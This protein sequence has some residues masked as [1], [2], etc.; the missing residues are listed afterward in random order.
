MADIPKAKTMTFIPRTQLGGAGD[1]IHAAQV[2][3]EDARL[4]LVI[5]HYGERIA[6][7]GTDKVIG[8]RD[9]LNA[10]IET[11]PPEEDHGA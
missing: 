11:L 3:R 8:L 1:Y 9:Y 4:A 6:I 10:M 2:L 7:A 5:T